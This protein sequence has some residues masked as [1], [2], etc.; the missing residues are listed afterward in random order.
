MKFAQFNSE[1]KPYS[2]RLTCPCGTNTGALFTDEITKFLTETQPQNERT[3]K[4]N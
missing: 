2:E 4:N 3:T 1:H